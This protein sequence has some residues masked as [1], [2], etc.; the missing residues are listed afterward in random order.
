M[1]PPGCGCARRRQFGT[2]SVSCGT[3]QEWVERS[4]GNKPFLVDQ[5]WK[6]PNWRQFIGNAGTKA[7]KEQ[8]RALSAHDLGE[9]LVKLDSM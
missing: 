7:F 1:T 6:R 3:A 8:F 9:I 2:Q 5:I 4:K